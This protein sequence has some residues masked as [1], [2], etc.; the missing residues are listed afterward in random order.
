MARRLLGT[1]VVPPVS[2]TNSGF[3]ARPLGTQRRTGP[4]R[5][6]SSWKGGNFRRSS[7]RPNL[8]ARV[9]AELRG[10]VQPERASGFGVEVPL[11]DVAHVIIELLL[12]LGGE[13][14]EIRGCGGAVHGIV[15]PRCKIQN[16]EAPKRQTTRGSGAGPWPAADLVGRPPRLGHDAWSMTCEIV[17][18]RA[19]CEAAAGQGPAPLRKS[20][21]IFLIDEQIR[22][23]H[24][25][26]G[27]FR[28]NIT[29]PGGRGSVS[30]VTRCRV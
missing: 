29:A 9:P 3:P 2:K 8:P 28:R 1:P 13:R 27:R 22:E 19:A 17:G 12:G 23:I 6:H 4:P 30:G 26:I 21:E 24:A 5:S 16:S 15:G 25:R 10:E 20:P 18:A 11:D 14:G 7:K